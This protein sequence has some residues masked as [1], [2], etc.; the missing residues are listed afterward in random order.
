MEL[1]GEPAGERGAGC[2]YEHGRGS[3]HTKVEWEPVDIAGVSN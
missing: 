2:D 1:G 3:A